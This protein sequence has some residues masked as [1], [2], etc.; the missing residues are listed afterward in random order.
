MYGGSDQLVSLESVNAATAILLKAAWRIS[1]SH[2]F[3]IA[4]ES[5]AVHV[6]GLTQN[7]HVRVVRLPGACCGR[8]RSWPLLML[9]FWRMR[10]ACVRVGSD[11]DLMFASFG[12]GNPLRYSWHAAQPAS[13]L[14]LTTSQP[15]PTDSS[16]CRST[17][18][19]SQARLPHARA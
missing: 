18:L 11:V 10:A 12:R 8:A 19:I 3:K 13:W 7:M 6:G 1:R 5:R 16:T 14:A 17:P 4:H 2:A 15:L 9:V